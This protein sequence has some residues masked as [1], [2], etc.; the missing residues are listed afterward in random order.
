MDHFS[1]GNLLAVEPCDTDLQLQG[2]LVLVVVDMERRPPLVVVVEE[3]DRLLLV[4]VVVVD[5]LPAGTHD[6]VEDMEQMV[7]GTI[8]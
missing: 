7:E 1:W 2:I 6:R 4:A 8:L 5:M 3:E